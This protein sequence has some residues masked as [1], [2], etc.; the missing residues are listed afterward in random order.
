MVVA[1]QD[2]PRTTARKCLRNRRRNAPYPSCKTHSRSQ[3]LSDSRF[4]LSGW[5]RRVDHAK[6][7]GII[8][9][10]Q[11]STDTSGSALVSRHV[12]GPEKCCSCPSLFAAFPKA[13]KTLTGF[14][15]FFIELNTIPLKSRQLVANT[16]HTKELATFARLVRSIVPARH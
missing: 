14:R 13:L 5:L 8:T 12:A 6:R 7:S 2:P 9:E 1:T 3:R 16:I 11:S 15:A 4:R 10:W